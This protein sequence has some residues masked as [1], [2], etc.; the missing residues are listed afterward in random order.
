MCYC[1]VPIAEG[2]PIIKAI[3]SVG[4]S[5]IA[6]RVVGVGRHPT[7]KVVPNRYALAVGTAA[8]A[9][10]LSLLVAPLDAW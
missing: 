7:E 4:R 3:H 1:R 8:L 10:S 5:R 9:L 6:R 2:T